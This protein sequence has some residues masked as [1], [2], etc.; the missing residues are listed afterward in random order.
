VGFW[1]KGKK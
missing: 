1:R